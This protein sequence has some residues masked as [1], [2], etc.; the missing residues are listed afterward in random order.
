[1]VPTPLPEIIEISSG[2]LSARLQP[3]I[4]GRM[5]HLVH[6]TL[7]DILVPTPDVPFDPANW[8][9]GGAYPLFP[10]HNRV[11]GASFM[12]EGRRI[13]LAPHPA[14]AGDAMHGPAH[15]RR[16]H[17][18]SHSDDCAELALDYIS[19]TDWPFDFQASQHFTLAHDR[20]DITLRLTNTGNGS[21]PGG[22]GWHPYFAASLDTTIECDAEVIWPLDNKNVPTGARANARTTQTLPDTPGYTF[23]LSKWSNATAI[24][25]GGAH[26]SL[27]ADSKLPHLAAHRMP[28]YV[29]LEPVSH[30]AGALSFTC[31]DSAKAGIAILQPGE[32]MSAS[33]SL[34]ILP[35]I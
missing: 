24:L 16:W 26:V 25:D 20:V 19:D 28:S 13:E 4:G 8:P 33:L 27:T 31:A 23:H 12:H 1:M 15:R 35:S 7:G 32:S 6:A 5:T 17:T 22:L 21:M 9:K 11:I 29:C 18:V 10:F 3:G 14:L 34:A 2:P 30:V